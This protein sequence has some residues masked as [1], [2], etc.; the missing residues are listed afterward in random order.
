METLLI[1]ILVIASAGI[2]LSV[3]FMA[4]DLL[5]SDKVL[6]CYAVCAVITLIALI[7]LGIFLPHGCR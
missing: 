5:D 4:L 1:I 6:A 7:L 3:L 2:A